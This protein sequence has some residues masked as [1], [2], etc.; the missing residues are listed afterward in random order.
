MGTSK[1]ID[2][3]GSFDVSSDHYDFRDNRYER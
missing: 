2:A 3:F 1:K